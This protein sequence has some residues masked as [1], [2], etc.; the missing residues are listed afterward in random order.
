MKSE[1]EKFEPMGTKVAPWAA[2]VWNAICESLGTDTYHLLQQF[3]YAMVRGASEGHDM[4]PDIKRLMSALDLDA[5]WQN[6]INL[7]APN[8]KLSI[9]QIIL[10]LEQEEKKGFGAVMLDK[11]FCGHCLQTE[12]VDSIFERLVEV[13]F[14]K[15]YLK[16]RELGR[17]KGVTSQREL[18]EMMLDEVAVKGLDEAF[19]KELPGMGE[20]TDTGKAYGYGK[21][22]KAKQK[23][24]PDSYA[25]DGRIKFDDYD[26]ELANT[27]A[28]Q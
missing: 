26:R 21:K 25:N 23:R 20:H 27:E 18:L 28:Q 9:S 11:P 12:N 17:L 22:T 2:H 13:I 4:S 16:L 10:I 8:G 19:A 1:E 3:I 24:T 14:K 5:G 15:T 6:A 7:C